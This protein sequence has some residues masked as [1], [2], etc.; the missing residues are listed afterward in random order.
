MFW[1]HKNTVFVSLTLCFHSVN[2]MFSPRQSYVFRS[3]ICHFGSHKVTPR[4]QQSATSTSTKCH[5]DGHKV[6]HRRP[7]SATST[8]SKS[9]IGNDEVVRRR[10]RR[11]NIF[12]LTRFRR[13]SFLPFSQKH[14][15]TSPNTPQSPIHKRFKASEVLLKHLTNT[16]LT[17]T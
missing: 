16:S 9:H 2:P 1:R 14:L 13:R 12:T 5:I 3:H 11:R 7:Q 8:G 6:P 17:L 15:T 4:R 10:E